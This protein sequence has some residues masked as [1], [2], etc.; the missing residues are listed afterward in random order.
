MKHNHQD[1][2]TAVAVVTIFAYA[3]NCTAIEGVDYP[4]FTAA[5]LRT[6]LE[7]LELQAIYYLH[8]KQ[9]YIPLSKIYGYSQGHVASR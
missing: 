6:W 9:P 2:D 3:L 7:G 5:F 4:N 1:Y 8:L